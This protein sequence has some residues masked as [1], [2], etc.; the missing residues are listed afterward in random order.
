MVKKGKAKSKKI[1]D[2]K[3]KGPILNQFQIDVLRKTKEIDKM[4][5]SI[6][7]NNTELRNDVD[8]T[9]NALEQL[10]NEK[11]PGTQHLIPGNKI[12]DMM[13]AWG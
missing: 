2:D 5:E 6:D 3:A 4:I 10:E 13:E 7:A 8:D 9:K 12:S 1:L 11:V